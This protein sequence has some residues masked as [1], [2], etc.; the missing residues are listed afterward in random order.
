MA[1]QAGTPL[2]SAGLLMLERAAGGSVGRC[3]QEQDVAGP[4]SR[5]PD[6]TPAEAHAV[7][8]WL[9]ATKRL[10]ASEVKTA[11]RK[12]NVFVEE[13]RAKLEALTGAGFGLIARAE[14]LRGHA[15]RERRRRKPSAKALAAWRAQGRY[16]AAVRRLSSGDRAKVKEIRE[17]KGVRA[18]IAAAKR[19][20][21]K[22]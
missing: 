14:S 22:R 7:L 5:F 13:I 8:K 12:R 19:L 15:S 3:K 11:L 9:V 18:A 4:L 16:M 2:P 21:S 6:I 20:A 1:P 17:A 10:A